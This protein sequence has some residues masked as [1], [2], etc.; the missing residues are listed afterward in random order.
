MS[1]IKAAPIGGTG[2]VLING[3]L[4][5]QSNNTIVPDNGGFLMVIVSGGIGISETVTTTTG[6]FVAGGNI[7]AG[8]TYPSALNIDGSLY[9]YGTNSRVSLSRGFRDKTQNNLRP[10]VQ[11][12]YRPDLLFSMPASLSKMITD[13]RIVK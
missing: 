10:A 3:S 7:S 11:V 8:G 5:V 2:V 6:I 12:N 1:N 9:T 13:W 4:G